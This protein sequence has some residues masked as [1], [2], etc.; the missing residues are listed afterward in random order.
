LSVKTPHGSQGG[1]GK[2]EG[3]SSA[4]VGVEPR[5]AEEITYLTTP[6]YNLV[7]VTVI[8]I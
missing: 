3:K 1:E 6:S 4:A 7:G 5:Q 2:K 8:V